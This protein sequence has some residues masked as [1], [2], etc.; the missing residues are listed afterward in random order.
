MK[1]DLE[2]FE[3]LITISLHHNDLISIQKRAFDN[4]E[5]ARMYLKYVEKEPK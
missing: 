4:I 1:N 2:E 5:L 3:K